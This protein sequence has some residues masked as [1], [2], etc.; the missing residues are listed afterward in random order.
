[1]LARVLLIA[2][3]LTAGSL[4]AADA[5]V[6]MRLK[7]AAEKVQTAVLKNDYETL[8]DMTYP[9]LVE[10]LGG[11]AKAVA[12]AKS[13][14]KGYKDKGVE[15]KNATAG[16]PTEPLK[17][18]S[19]LY[20]VIPTTTE[21]TAPQGKVISKGYMIGVSS[22]QGKTWRFVHGALDAEKIRKV[23]PDL[24]EKLVLPKRDIKIV[25]D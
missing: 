6:K 23:L 18:G 20:A 12:N 2:L 3:M 15:I 11:K 16:E 25:K 13:A 9:K 10:Q 24:P 22:D 8:I 7:A 19:E 4:T 14:L 17:G 5:D 21:M 1:M